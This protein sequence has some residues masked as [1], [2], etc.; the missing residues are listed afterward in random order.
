MRTPFL[1]ITLALL[2]ACSDDSQPQA[3][4]SPPAA[5]A[6]SAKAPAPAEPADVAAA[7]AAEPA[8]DPC[9][10]SGYDMSKMTVDLHEDLV[11]ACNQSKQ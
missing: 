10:L 9:D 6:A 3:S 8:V 2:A 11:K 5:Q 7:E 1:L 4:A